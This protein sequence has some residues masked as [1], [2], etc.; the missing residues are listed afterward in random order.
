MSKQTTCQTKKE[1]TSLKQ[2]DLCDDD[3]DG[4]F[5]STQ[6]MGSQATP[7]VTLDEA[8]NKSEGLKSKEESMHSSHRDACRSPQGSG[9][10]PSLNSGESF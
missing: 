2:V 3:L 8:P 5:S 9:D 1:A 6:D 10:E 7:D 4:F